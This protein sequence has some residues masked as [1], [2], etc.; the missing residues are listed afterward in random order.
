MGWYYTAV[1]LSPAAQGQTLAGQLDPLWLSFAA[2]E[3]VYTMRAS[4]TSHAAYPLTLYVLADHRVEKDAAFG[5]SEVAF[6]GWVEPEEL[7]AASALRERLPRRMFLTKFRE[8]IEPTEVTGDYVFIFA[9]ADTEYYETITE[10]VYD[11]YT[12]M[13]V[14]GLLCCGLAI[15]GGMGGGLLLAR[16]RGRRAAQA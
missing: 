13:W 7:G 10:V 1:K 11:D 15:L 4:A 14:T 2:S 8:Q 9:E 3:P 5:F 12:W 6:A 16:R